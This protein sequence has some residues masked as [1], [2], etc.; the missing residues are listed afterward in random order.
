MRYLV[1]L[2]IP[3]LI[4]VTVMFVVA[5]NRRRR[6]EAGEQSD[7]EKGMFIFILVIGALVTVAIVVALQSFWGAG[8]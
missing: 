1:Q 5:R 2:I 4:I 6:D 3:V 8:A 7:S